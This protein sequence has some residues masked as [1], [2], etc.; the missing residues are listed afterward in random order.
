MAKITPAE[1]VRQ[2]RVEAIRK[3]TWPT[4][5]EAGVSTLTV[6]AM[7]VVVALFFFLIDQVFAEV[8]QLILG[9]GG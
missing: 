1:F 6:F 3:V 9:L 5:K 8:I 4:T 7:I 2:V